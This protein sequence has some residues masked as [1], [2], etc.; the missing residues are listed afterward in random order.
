MEL[1]PARAGHN[2]S[3]AMAA[4]IPVACVKLQGTRRCPNDVSSDPTLPTNEKPKPFRISTIFGDDEGQDKTD[5][6]LL[7]QISGTGGGVG[8]FS[9]LADRPAAHDERRGH[10]ARQDRAFEHFGGH[11]QGWLQRAHWPP[12]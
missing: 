2:P 5:P 3:S 11:Q 12:D 1:K 9:L 10:A 4:G 8:N 6:L 7:A